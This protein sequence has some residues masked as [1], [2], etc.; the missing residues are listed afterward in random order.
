M[1]LQKCIYD[2]LWCKGGRYG[3]YINFYVYIR[4]WRYVALSAAIL[5][6]GFFLMH[7]LSLAL[8]RRSLLG[9]YADHKG[10][11]RRGHPREAQVASAS[12]ISN[13]RWRALEKPGS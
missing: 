10:R 2:E 7:A 8:P 5:H 3:R 13:W 11:Y 9:L 12:A 1:G 6:F 4:L